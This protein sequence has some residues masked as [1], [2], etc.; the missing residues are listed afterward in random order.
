MKVVRRFVDSV[1]TSVERLISDW[2][3]ADVAASA[4]CAPDHLLPPGG[5]ATGE[6]TSGD[7]ECRCGGS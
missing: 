6:D 5:E 4:C 7:D 3:E 1:R 2:D